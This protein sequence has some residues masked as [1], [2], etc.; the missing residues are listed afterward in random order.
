MRT[1]AAAG[2]EAGEEVQEGPS[3]ESE[4]ED[5]CASW[6]R[7]EGRRQGE[8]G[9]MRTMRSDEYAVDCRTKKTQETRGGNST[10]HRFGTHR[11]ALA[12]SPAA[13]RQGAL[14]HNV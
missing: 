11:L 12:R 7:D 5:D 4:E 2:E 6:G 8:G 3:G 14:C 10:I 9:G 1:E 13:T